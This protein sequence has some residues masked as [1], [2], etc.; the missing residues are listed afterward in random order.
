MNLKIPTGWKVHYEGDVYRGRDW[1]LVATGACA[2]PEFLAP[3]CKGFW[4]LGPKAIAG[5]PQTGTP[6]TGKYSFS[7]T[8]DQ[9]YCPFDKRDLWLSEGKP[10]KGLRQV[11]PGHTAKYA[12]W[13]A[14]CVSQDG[15]ERRTAKFAQREWFLPTSKILVVD[16]WNTPSLPNILKNAT[17]S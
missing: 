9:P 2:K 15:S 14:S 6:Y 16:Y 11:G 1:I 3:N 7:P 4:V 13:P 10:T 17:W 8:L 12:S 5:D